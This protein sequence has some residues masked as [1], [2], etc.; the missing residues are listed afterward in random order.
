MDMD[1]PR[2]KINIWGYGYH[3]MMHMHVL[4]YMVMYSPAA[5]MHACI[6]PTRN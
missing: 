6:V 5:N 3:I 1:I 2:K 4:V